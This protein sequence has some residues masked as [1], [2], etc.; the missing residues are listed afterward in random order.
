MRI[1]SC[2][3][4]GCVVISGVPQGSL[5]GPVLFMTFAND[6]TGC[7]DSPVTVRPKLFADDKKKYSAIMDDASAICLQSYL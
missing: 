5:L 7:A 3:S 6:I 4:D 2:L 1:D